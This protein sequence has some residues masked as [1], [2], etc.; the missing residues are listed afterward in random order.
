MAT[1]PA[2]GTPQ[3]EAL[4]YQEAIPPF[5]S[6]LGF[7]FTYPL[8]F[9]P[10]VVISV[11]SL[12]S[13]IT[14]F[15][16][17]LFRGIIA[18]LFLR[19]A[20]SVMEQAAGGDLNAESPDVNMWGGKD[21]RPAKQALVFLVYAAM[22]FGL[23][24]LATIA[25]PP[26]PIDTAR[27]EAPQAPATPAATPSA[28]SDDEDD[29]A[30]AADRRASRYFDLPDTAAEPEPQTRLAWWFY[31]LAIVCAIP[32]P[33]AIMV[34]A[35]E[36]RLVSALN[37]LTTLA[38][39]RGMGAA[40]FLLWLFF[41]LILVSRSAILAALPPD[42]SAFLRV[43]IETFVGSYMMLALFAMMGYCLYQ[44]HSELGYEVK[45]DF[46]SHRAREAAAAPDAKPKDPLTQKIDT[47][48]A[49]G[50]VDDALR[51]VLDE[52]R[53]EKL[54]PDLHERAHKLYVMKGDVPKIV[55]HGQAYLKA[56]IVAKRAAPA[57]QL[58]K[59]LKEIDPAFE[60]APETLLG[61]AECAYAVKDYD[62]AIEL[63]RGF[64]KRFPGHGDIPGVYLLGARIT[65]EHIGQRDKAMQILK[66]LLQR[67]PD[68]P[69]AEEAKK[70]LSALAAA[71]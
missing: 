2:S 20:F 63:V 10:M 21:H 67:F 3:P 62:R 55:A 30:P 37:P 48:L 52:L 1:A 7:F 36:D 59:K 29:D 65:T 56:L 50:K 46:D 14:A 33:A 40:Y 18:Y 32:L 64:D 53:F 23:A 41:A 58:A 5:W 22:L 26:K 57:M 4:T 71:S 51:F 45:M 9:G 47:A 27:V 16:G 13:A 43:P 38:Y 25:V 34:I 12:A 11:L 60:P 19:Y 24:N 44:Y 70:Y 31:V 69:V 61:L 68:A 39:L 17:G 49:A 28:A 42:M 35:V 6:K 8:R 15:T 54:N 66:V